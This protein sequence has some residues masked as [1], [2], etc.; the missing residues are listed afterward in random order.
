MTVYVL[1][2]SAL[3]RYLDKEA[4]WDRVKVVL[5]ECVGGHAGLQISAVQWGEVAGNLRKRFGDSEPARMRQARILS[6]LL[7]SEALVVPVNAERAVHA[8]VLKADCQI[9]YAGAFAVD[10]AMSSPDHVLVTA[11]D[12]LKAVADM[13]RIEFLSAK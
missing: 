4:G 11:D 5:K 9:A 1:D 7:P 6:G 3:I 13:V 10:L 2:A 12:G 8:A